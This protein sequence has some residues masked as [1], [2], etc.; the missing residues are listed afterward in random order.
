MT[1]AERLRHALER[2]AHPDT[3][4]LPGDLP[5]HEIEQSGI[6]APAAVLV[7]ITDRFEPGVILTKRTE[8]LARHPG[9]V[10]FP[11]GRIDAGDVDAI[12]A[13]LREAEE[14]IA[15][16]RHVVDIIGTVDRYR[17]VTGFSVTP[18]L[19]VV[20]ADLALTPQPSEVQTIFEVPLAFLLDPANHVR[21][22][23]EYRGTTRHFHEMFWD[24][25]R[26]WGATAAMIVNLS[27]RLR[28][29]L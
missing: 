20:P 13:A 11:G 8:T 27:Q 23:A 4:L 29:S 24:G 25:H 14:E 10:A 17:T 22:S 12:A 26:I 6:D 3:V 28:W 2:P 1:L 5:A 19:G 15:M 16:P 21:A 7:A 18:V 9:Q